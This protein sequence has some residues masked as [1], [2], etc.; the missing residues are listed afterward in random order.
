MTTGTFKYIDLDS[1]TGKPWGKV[2]VD[3]T[4][5]Q[6]VER[7]RSVADMRA[8]GLDNF[9][10]ETA[11]FGVYHAPSQE[12]AFTDDAAVRGPYYAEVEALLRAKLPGFFYVKDMTPDE[13]M[14][15]KCFDSRG[16]GRPRGTPGRADYTPH[17]AFVDP[18]TPEGAKGRQ[19]IEVRCL[20][21]YEDGA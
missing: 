21:F 14:F 20:V 7:Q 13:A 15:I 16:Q 10:T 8:A 9:S 4:S 6:R 18:Q 12:K 1:F 5:Y 3:K 2:D 17:T 11:G 19:S